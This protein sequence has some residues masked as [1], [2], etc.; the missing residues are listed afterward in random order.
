MLVFSTSAWGGEVSLA[1][2]RSNGGMPSTSNA[3]THHQQR[4]ISKF[5]A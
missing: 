2:E 5:E 4:G 3:S 1:H